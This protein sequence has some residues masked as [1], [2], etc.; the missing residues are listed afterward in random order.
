MV[1]DDRVV[2]DV[3]AAPKDHVV[4]DLDEWL[5]R[6]VLEY[7]AV[8]PHRSVGPHGGLGAH[9]GDQLVSHVSCLLADLR[10]DAVHT[11]I[12]DGYVHPEAG[13]GE[14]IHHFF[15]GHDRE[16]VHLSRRDPVSV[17]R[18]RDRLMWAVLVQVRPDHLGERGGTEDHDGAVDAIPLG[19]ALIW[20]GNT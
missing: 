7:E 15:E 14:L 8:V 18:E 1:A 13:W 20:N 11:R 5:D 16:P 12:A 9:V 4:T 17:H 19:P 10:S 2:A 3:V 6:V